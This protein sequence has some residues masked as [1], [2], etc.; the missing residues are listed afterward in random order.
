MRNAPFSSRPLSSKMLLMQGNSKLVN[1][2]Q[3][4]KGC[5]IP[6]RFQQFNVLNIVTADLN[7]EIV[8]LTLYSFLCWVFTH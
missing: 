3:W 5:L 7:S 4:A 6:C 2:V 1:L 8:I